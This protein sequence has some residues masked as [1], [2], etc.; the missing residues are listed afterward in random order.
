MKPPV[1]RL[2]TDRTSIVEI[3]PGT[4][5][6]EVPKQLMSAVIEQNA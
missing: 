2:Y 6:M 1:A 3:D 5:V 4:D